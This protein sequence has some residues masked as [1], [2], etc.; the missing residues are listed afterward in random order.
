MRFAASL[1]AGITL[2]S[3]L[4]GGYFTLGAFQIEADS[5]QS[6][7]LLLAA[8]VQITPL[9][10]SLPLDVNVCPSLIRI[11]ISDPECHTAQRIGLR[12]L[13]RN[14]KFANAFDAVLP[15][16]ERVRPTAVGRAAV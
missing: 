1:G 16:E 9:T 3:L 11:P 5:L 2:G 12:L 8:R 13:L 6:L 7:L 4:S 10:F 14:L 15:S